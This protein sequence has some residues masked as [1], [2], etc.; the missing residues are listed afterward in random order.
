MRTSETLNELFTAMCK[1]QGEM[2]P[3][4][5][6]NSNT[7][8][9]KKTTNGDSKNVFA[10]HG[11]VWASIRVPL[12]SNGLC[13][14]QEAVTTPEGVA[15][16]TRICHCSGQWI[17]H[18]PFV[19]PVAKRDAHSVG[20]AT[21]YAKR[22][23]LVAAIGV[24]T[25]DHDDDGNIATDASISLINSADLRTLDSLLVNI[26]EYRKILEKKLKD[27]KGITCLSQIPAS[28]APAILKK[29]SDVNARTVGITGC[30]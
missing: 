8:F 28:L 15:I 13:V 9:T 19:V 23:A 4:L 3:A 11:D 2:K 14:F 10:D 27:D 6:T 12:T 25:A 18:G 7:R 22:N 20:S 5:C 30:L 29:A 1:A 17:E 24:V 21:T 16:N 26:P